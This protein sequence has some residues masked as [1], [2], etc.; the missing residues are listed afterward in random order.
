MKKM[1]K[2]TAAMLLALSMALS[3]AACGGSNSSSSSTG[4]TPS[5]DAN[6]STPSQSTSSTPAEPTGDAEYAVVLKVLSSQFW[7]TMRDGVLAEAEARGIK[8]DVF[9]AN[10]EDDVEGQ[11][12]LLENAISKGY[13]GIAVAPI[14]A[15]NLNNAI[16]DATSKGIYIV[17]ID[18]KVNMEGL[19][20]LGG[21][22]YS[23]VST[24]NVAVGRM[25]AQYI[26]DQIGGTGQVAIIEGKAG[27]ASGEDRKKGATEAF[28]A[29]GLELVESQPA[30]WDRT[31]AYDLAT[32]YINKYPDLK[33]IY[34]CNDTMAMGAVEA[35][36]NAG[37]DILVVGTD[38][39]DDAVQS[40][41]DGDLAATVAQDPAKIGARGLQMLIEASEGGVTIDENY[42][43]TSEGI[44]AILITKDNN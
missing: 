24:D 38:G 31:K 21:N 43:P 37:K 17:N 7:Q 14:S 15:D 41:K 35:V 36:K 10:T 29:D 42:E 32:N 30:D 44:D 1:L 23:F 22:V 25:G 20:A 4:S 18:E 28:S 6:A 2:S 3:M 27:A 8:V 40:V 26:V 12:T 19:K 5:S 9:A 34:C 13:K 11:V 39:N 16:A 33:G